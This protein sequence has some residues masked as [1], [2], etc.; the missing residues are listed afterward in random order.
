MIGGKE[1]FITGF[2]HTN[3]K[4]YDCNESHQYDCSNAYK[5]TQKQ[6]EAAQCCGYCTGKKCTTN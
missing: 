4:D 5:W 6:R 2:N 3:S 1:Y